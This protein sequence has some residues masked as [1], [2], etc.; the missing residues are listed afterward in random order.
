MLTVLMNGAPL[1][2]LSAPTWKQIGNW[3]FADVQ[4]H[5]CQVQD[6]AGQLLCV[7]APEAAPASA[8]PWG[9]FDVREVIH[10]VRPTFPGQKES[11]KY[12]GIPL[13]TLARV[14]KKTPTWW[15]NLQN[16]SITDLHMATEDGFEFEPNPSYERIGPFEDTSRG[17]ISYQTDKTFAV[18]T[19]DNRD[20]RYLIQF[21][22]GPGVD[23]CLMVLFA[24]A[25]AKGQ[26]D[27]DQNTP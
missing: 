22:F 23:P 20:N 7:I 4:G 15:I 1:M 12:N 10:T 2:L 11:I 24:V 13:Y 17:T 26:M 18:A 9:G 14:Q 21:N 25:S 8:H 19:A 27:C 16:K 5:I 6:P 3:K